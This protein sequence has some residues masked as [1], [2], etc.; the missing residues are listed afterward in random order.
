MSN[1]NIKRLQFPAA[2]P[3]FYPLYLFVSMVLAIKAFKTDA[4]IVNHRQ[5]SQWNKIEL[6]L[7]LGVR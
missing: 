6:R 7:S 4:I 5:L 3:I 2:F 1:S